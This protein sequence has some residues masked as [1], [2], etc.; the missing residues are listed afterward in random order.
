MTH[1]SR[2]IAARLTCTTLAA[3]LACLAAGGCGPERDTEVRL[4][5]PFAAR[6]TFAVAPAMNFSGSRDFDPLQVSDLFASELGDVDNLTVLPV[7]RVLAELARQRTPQIG[8]PG[9]A[10]ETARAL[11]ADGLFVLGITEHDPYD[12]PVVGLAVQLYCPGTAAGPP[13]IDPLAATRQARPLDVAATA[14]RGLL[15]RLQVQRVYNAAHGATARRVKAYAR[16]RSAD[17]SPY[18]WRKYLKSQRLY[19]RFCCWAAIAEML[20]GDDGPAPRDDPY[21]AG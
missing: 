19:L 6:M 3:G 20:G 17:A 16:R 21:G 10:V 9:H 4:V 8:S 11:G 2:M 5:S 1:R 7:N 14:D 15:P 18:G 12:P 13:T